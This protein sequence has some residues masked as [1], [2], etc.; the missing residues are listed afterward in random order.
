MRNDSGIR[1]TSVPALLTATIPLLLA[2]ALT[3]CSKNPEAAEIPSPECQALAKTVAEQEQQFVNRVKEIRSRHITLQEYDQQM[4]DAISAR[5]DALQSTT[6]MAM[7]VTDEISG[8]RGKALDDMRRNA[9]R[10]IADY[11]V[12]IT[13]FKN[14]L[15][16]DPA[17]VY[18]DQQ[19]PQQ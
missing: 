7:S 18:I 16:S 19:R 13:T 15:R 12:Y 10:Q 1:K 5:R 11:R 8:C 14:A 4:I 3:G 9:Q 6:L 2:A 17:N